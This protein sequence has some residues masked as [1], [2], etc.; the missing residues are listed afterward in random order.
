M[1][2]NTLHFASLLCIYATFASVLIGAMDTALGESTVPLPNQS[3]LNGL[4]SPRASEMFFEEG[5]R[6]I[7]R[8]TRILLNPER[9]KSEGILKNNID[10]TK[11]IEQLEETNPILNFPKDSLQR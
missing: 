6:N 9:Y 3:V 4:Y 10:N 2:L 8:E 5:R 7:Q 1:K 11:I